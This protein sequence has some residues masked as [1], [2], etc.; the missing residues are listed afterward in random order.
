ML[1]IFI[2][3]SSSNRILIKLLSE[4]SLDTPCNVSTLCNRIKCLSNTSILLDT[5]TLIV[6]GLSCTQASA[7]ACTVAIL[8]QECKVRRRSIPCG[9]A[10]VPSLAQTRT[11]VQDRQ[12]TG[13]RACSLI[14]VYKRARLKQR[15]SMPLVRQYDNERL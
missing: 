4:S 10:T 13:R 7:A 15:L 5:R 6:T 1:L 11:G 2:L 14:P 3:I 9:G 12:R 8:E